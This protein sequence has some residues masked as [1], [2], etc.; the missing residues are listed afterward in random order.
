MSEYFTYSIAP[1]CIW[2]YGLRYLLSDAT[3]PTYQTC[4]TSLEMAAR[5]DWCQKAAK[6]N[7]MTRKA[8]HG[9]RQRPAH[10]CLRVQTCLSTFVITHLH[11]H[12]EKMFERRWEMQSRANWLTLKVQVQCCNKLQVVILDGD[13]VC[14]SRNVFILFVKTADSRNLFRLKFCR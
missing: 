6:T 8:W 13:P 5:S 4:K 1:C 2:S 10:S 14:V 12:K 9:N 3:I 11:M 7:T